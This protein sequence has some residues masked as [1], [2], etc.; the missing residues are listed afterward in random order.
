MA[1]HFAR[2]WDVE[3]MMHFPSGDPLINSD[4][5]WCKRKSPGDA[6]WSVIIMGPEG[7]KSWL[8]EKDIADKIRFPLS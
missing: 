5:N 3:M 4:N 7:V 6:R 8:A 1:F 2:S